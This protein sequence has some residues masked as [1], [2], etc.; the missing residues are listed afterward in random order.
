M[1]NNDKTERIRKFDD[2]HIKISFWMRV[3]PLKERTAKIYKN[4][5]IAKS[6]RLNISARI[7]SFPS[8]VLPPVHYFQ[9][10]TLKGIT[11]CSMCGNLLKFSVKEK[12]IFFSGV[13]SSL[14]SI[15]INNV[16]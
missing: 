7:L 6:T 1:N 9:V 2:S 12:H 5:L 13:S 11:T 16:I 10:N 8:V 15:S 4:I 14:H 3:D